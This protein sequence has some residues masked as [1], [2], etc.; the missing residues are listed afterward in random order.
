[1]KRTRRTILA[2]PVAALLALCAVAILAGDEEKQEEPTA[3][4]GGE[5]RARASV[6]TDKPIYRPGGT[7]WGRAVLA[8]AFTAAP[9][10]GSLSATWS[11]RSPKGDVVFKGVT[12]FSRGVAPF[13]WEIPDALAGGEYTLQVDF[14]RHGYPPAVRTFDIRSYR[15]PRFRTQIRFL[16]KGYGPGE[17]VTATCT[18][19]RAEGGVPDGASVTALARLDGREIARQETSID[20][21]GTCTVRFDLPETIQDGEGTL[22]FLI[23]D[24]GVQETAVKTLPVLLNRVRLSFHPEGGDLVAGL[25]ARVFFEARNHRGKPADVAGRILGP[26][27]ETTASFSSEHEGRGRFRFTPESDVIYTAVLDEPAGNTQRFPLPAVKDEGCTLRAGSKVYAGKGAFWFFIAST[28]TMKARLAL[29]RLEKEIASREV[30]LAAGEEKAVALFPTGPA[31]GV[32]RATLFDGDGLPRAERLVFARPREGID[33]TVKVDP[34]TASPGS[35]VEVEIRTRNGDGDPVPATVCLAVTDDAVLEKIETREQAPR[36]PAQILLESDVKELE[37]ARVYLDGSVEGDS[38]LDLL[39]GTQGWRRFVYFDLED[40]LEKGADEARRAVAHRK[41]PRVRRL[42]LMDKGAPGGA[43]GADVEGE[44]PREEAA[45]DGVPEAAVAP[46]E[47]KDADDAKEEAEEAR[48]EEAGKKRKE[49]A[50]RPALERRRRGFADELR[51]ARYTRQYAHKARP[52]RKPGERVDFAE[53]LFWDAGLRTD[54]NGRATFTFDLSDSVTTFRVLA[55]AISDEGSLDTADALIVSRKAFYLE[56]KLPLEITAGD[57]VEAPVALFNGTDGDLQATLEAAIGEGLVLEGAEPATTVPAGRSKRL[58]LTLVGGRHNGAVE[59]RLSGKAGAH[60]D[61]VTRT[62]PV[63]PAGFPVDQAFG[64]RLEGSARGR[65]TIPASVSPGSRVARAAVYPS[66]LATLTEALKGLLREPHGCFE[67]TSSAT[68]PNVMVMNYFASHR[69]SDPALVDRTRGLLERGYK[70][71]VGYECKRKGYEWFGGDPGHEALTAYGLMEFSDMSGVFDVDAEMVQ[72]TRRWLLE[73]RDGEGGFKRN[74]RALDSFG[75]A[76]KD[77]TDAYILWALL[78]A[79]ETGLEGEVASIKKRA[80]GAKDPYFLAL[81]ANILLLAEDGSAESIL[82]KLGRMQAEDGSVPGAKT[83]ITCSR[84]TGLDIETTSLA[85]LAWLKSGKHAG[86]VEKASGWLFKRCRGGRFGSTQSTILALKAILGY[87]ASR[88]R[89]KAPGTVRLVVDGDVC[90]S[91]AFDSRTSGPLAFP[92]FGDRLGP[93]EHTVAIVMEGGSPM[94]FAVDVRYHASTPANHPDCPVRLTTRLTEPETR[95]GETL[96]AL[97]RLESLSEE[98]LPMTVAIVGLPGGLEP[99]HDQL[100]E[101]VKAKV[102]DFYEVIGRDVVLYWRC[103]KPGAVREIPL[104]LTAA[105]PGVYTGP[106]SRAYL[107]YADD[108]KHWVPGMKST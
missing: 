63:A 68:Y 75:R 30:E 8:D 43:A 12:A 69:V 46:D 17:T 89:P 31:V 18:A 33:V 41:K 66:P 94:P 53:T 67:Q 108:Q 83:S 10:Q 105:V 92:D 13:Q 54:E 73:R 99:R 28:K 90:A 47:A 82:E 98:G 5:E 32:V 39:L 71:L 61:G 24:G 48:L 80:L 79:G 3:I 37:D 50:A 2:P 101:M 87:D 26:G 96:E 45:V 78:E 55:D 102:V 100:K 49:P 6:S 22:A 11:V 4:L 25:P 38:A 77:V 104:S 34:A 42:E 106:A 91:I 97:V 57:V 36:L 40:F 27:G 65:F 95:E 59:V 76:P 15:A 86:R 84:G 88:A 35:T 81:A 44:A 14:P 60:V 62:L 72:R 103:L 51:V 23:R 56:P 20:A 85:I 107:Y 70:R 74:A 93:G 9:V 19:E 16:R 21:K 58:Y 52:G 7:V 29:F 64:G 1:M